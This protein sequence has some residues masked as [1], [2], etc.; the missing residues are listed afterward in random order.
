MGIINFKTITKIKMFTNK[1][2]LLTN[3]ESEEYIPMHNQIKTRSTIKKLSIAALIVGAVS[4]GAYAMMPS[5]VPADSE[6]STNGLSN[7][8]SKIKEPTAR[9]EG[10]CGTPDLYRDEFP[11]YCK[12][13]K[14]SYGCDSDIKI[15]LPGFKNGSLRSI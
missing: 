15:I 13:M 12:E 11:T 6:E 10:W 1:Q 3:S 14:E 8:L 5:N 9:R 2:S 4:I 7:L